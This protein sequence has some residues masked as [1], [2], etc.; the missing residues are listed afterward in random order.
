[1][2]P[3]EANVAPVQTGSL[4]GSDALLME[5][6]IV[7]SDNPGLQKVDFAPAVH[8]A[9]DQFELGDLPLGLAVRPFRTGC[10]TDRRLVFDDA[11]NGGEGN[12][13]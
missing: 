4:L 11:V 10:G 7:E 1:M 12:V 8:L 9:L 6:G 2:M 3:M 5:L 13:K